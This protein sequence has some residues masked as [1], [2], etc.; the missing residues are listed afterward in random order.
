MQPHD[1]NRVLSYMGVRA[2]TPEEVQRVSGGGT[3]H[4]NNCT[5][6]LDTGS[7]DGD[8]CLH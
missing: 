3:V 7:K 1:E 2:L 4:T 8:A 5:I 6:N